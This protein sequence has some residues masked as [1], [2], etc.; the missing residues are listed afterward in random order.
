M[1]ARPFTPTQALPAPLPPLSR[2]LVRLAL[3]W[4]EWED[5]ARGRRALRHLDPHLLRDIGLN[6]PAAQ[7]EIAK[8]FW[9]N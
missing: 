3:I 6:A 1:P 8:L 5:R 4:A 2:L 9:R 7:E